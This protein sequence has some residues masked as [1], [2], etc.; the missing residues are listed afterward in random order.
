MIGSLR[1]TVV[2]RSTKGQ[3]AEV[4]IEVNGVGYL[5]SVTPAT[6]AKLSDRESV[7]LHVHTHVREDALVLYGFAS[8][9]ERVC[10]EMLL[11]THGVGTSLALAILSSLTPVA[12]QT[13]VA[14]DDGDALTAVPGVGKKTA[15]RLLIELKSKLDVADFDGGSVVGP[16]DASGPGRERADVRE[17]LTALG[18][19]PDEIRSVLRQLP[20]EGTTAQ[21]LRQALTRLGPRT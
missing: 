7:F 16:I 6:A 2:E 10:F 21:L 8:R 19:G 12:L 20:P 9:E 3:N 4:I 15:A 11:S 1:G 18:Y 17:A 13:A 14:A 5:L